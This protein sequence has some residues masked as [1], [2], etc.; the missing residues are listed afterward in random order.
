LADIGHLAALVAPRPLVLPAA[1]EPEGGLAT[2]ERIRSAFD[3]TR[4]I[5]ELVGAID[6]L[7][8]GKPGDLRALASAR[9]RE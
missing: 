5:Y 8:L 2:L 9:G 7:R 3:F 6:R 4:R 1:I